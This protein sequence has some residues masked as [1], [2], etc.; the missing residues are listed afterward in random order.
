MLAISVVENKVKTFWARIDT[1]MPKTEISDVG[2]TFGGNEVIHRLTY[3]K[4]IELLGL[5]EEFDNIDEVPCMKGRTDYLT[6]YLKGV[7]SRI[8]KEFT[9]SLILFTLLVENCSLFSQFLTVSSFSKYKNTLKNFNKVISATSKEELLHG[10]FGAHLVNIIRKENPDWFDQDMEDKIRR[11]VRKAYKA[12]SE[13]LDWMLEGGEL[14][15]I[16]KAEILEY[17]K[18]R[19]ND[20]LQQMGYDAEYEV[21][22]DLLKKS[23]YMETSLLTTSDVDFFDGK[24]TDYDM[25][26]T[27]EDDELW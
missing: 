11:A 10:K 2:H 27:Y 25:N 18:Y 21:Y 17:L 1:R 24:V 22:D 9:K 23:Q 14:D 4:L 7:N 20:S 13:V 26:N 12:E 8:N 16:S 15:H 5:Q 19:L 6:K 3:A